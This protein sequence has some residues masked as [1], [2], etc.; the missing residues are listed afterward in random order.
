M[1]CTSQK[2]SK[3]VQFPT[4][5]M[6]ETVQYIYYTCDGSPPKGDMSNVLEGMDAKEKAK[7]EVI[8]QGWK[9]TTDLVLLKILYF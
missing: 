9:E 3:H 2:R 6:L 4:G 5:D 1:D 8:G 7:E